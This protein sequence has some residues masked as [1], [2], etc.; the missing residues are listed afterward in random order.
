MQ[1]LNRAYLGF[2]LSSL[3]VSFLGWSCSSAEMAGGQGRVKECKPTPTKPCGNSIGDPEPVGFP[4]VPSSL[5]LRPALAVRQANCVLCHGTVVGDVITDFNATQRPFASRGHSGAT[6]EQF[7]EEVIGSIDGIRPQNWATVNIKGKLAIPDVKI[8]GRF[9]KSFNANA[10]E[11]P[12]ESALRQDYVSL[13]QG[14]L[15]AFSGKVPIPTVGKTRDTTKAGVNEISVLKKILINPP[16]EDEI[17]KLLVIPEAKSVIPSSEIKVL[18]LGSNARLIGFGVKKGLTD[19]FYAINQSSTVECEGDIVVGGTLVLKDISQFKVGPTGCRLY[20]QQSVFIKG[21]IEAAGVAEQ[22]I[23]I[24]SGRAIVAGIRF[25]RSISDPVHAEIQNV[26]NDIEDAGI[27]Y[28]LVK[29]ASNGTITRLATTE[30]NYLRF[31]GGPAEYAKVGASHLK[32]LGT[33]RPPANA[34]CKLPGTAVT[35]TNNGQDCV[36]YTPGEANDDQ[37]TTRKSV[38]FDGVIFAS[39]RVESRYFGSFKGAIVADFALF[40]LNRLDFQADERFDGKPAFPWLG[41]P[42]LGLE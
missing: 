39:P 41:R 11:I 2:W 28:Y 14:E 42:L 1:Q 4:V 36:F 38:R 6:P 13:P 5:G 10:T 18:G 32:W 31:P 9:A 33:A 17:A 22:G 19:T 12:L 20:V 15:S 25:G 27:I 8:T 40:S 35:G 26:G 29:V 24:A 16:T 34:V 3:V 7:F 37:A 23:Q 21:S 30:Y